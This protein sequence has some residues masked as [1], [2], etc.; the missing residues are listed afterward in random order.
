MIDW[1]REGLPVNK[2]PSYELS[3]QCACKLKTRI[4]AAYRCHVGL[5]Q[6]VGGVVGGTA[7]AANRG[8]ER[9]ELG[10]EG[11]RDGAGLDED[12]LA[13]ERRQFLAGRL[14]EGGQGRLGGR[15]WSRY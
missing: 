5:P 2:D 3:G 8:R 1:D 10:L 15:L 4:G 9:V 14:G 13:A 7:I 12:H 11:G 6:L